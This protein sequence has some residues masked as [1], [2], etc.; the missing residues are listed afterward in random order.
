MP[1]AQCDGP[2][3]SRYAKLD[4]EFEKLSKD[5]DKELLERN[6]LELQ[7]TAL[8]ELL[9]KPWRENWYHGYQQEKTNG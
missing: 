7:V 3:Q 1:P 2:W 6:K 8:N 4:A 9:C 5:Y